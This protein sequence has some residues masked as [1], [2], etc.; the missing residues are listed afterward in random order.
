MRRQTLEAACDEFLRAC[1]PRHE[2]FRR[3][4]D[5]DPNPNA[6]IDCSLR[7]RNFPSFLYGSESWAPSETTWWPHRSAG[8][9]GE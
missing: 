3:K 2:P 7:E 6:A 1:E 4:T 8:W 9:V 5:Q